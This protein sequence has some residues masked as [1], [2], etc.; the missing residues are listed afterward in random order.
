MARIKEKS[1][2]TTLLVVDVAANTY[3]KEK[4]IAISADLIN[5]QADT[6]AMTDEEV[7]LAKAFRDGSSICYVRVSPILPSPTC[8]VQW[9]S[10]TI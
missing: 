6:T 7:S 4:N 3:F 2:E 9:V 8:L 1:G 5:A 10:T